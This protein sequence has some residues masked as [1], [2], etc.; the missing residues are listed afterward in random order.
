[1]TA[2]LGTHVDKCVDSRGKNIFVGDKVMVRGRF[3][4]ALW[5]VTEIEKMPLSKKTLV[6]LKGKNGAV[7]GCKQSD[8]IEKVEDHT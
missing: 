8:E 5:T 1:M 6:T 3:E 2:Y 7:G 4:C